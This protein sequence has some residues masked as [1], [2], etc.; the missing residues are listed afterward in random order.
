MDD[1]LAIRAPMVTFHVLRDSSGLYLI[2]TGFFWA[3]TLLHRA[4]RRRGWQDERIRGILLTHGHVDHVYNA[5]VLAKETGAWIAAPRLDALHLEGRFPYRGS[6][7]V[8]GALESI[9]RRVCGYPPIPITHC[10]TIDPTWESGMISAR[11]IC[12]DTPMATWDFFHQ[13]ASSCSA[14]I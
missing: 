12:P 6:A 5:A 1:L 3:R 11:C 7:R 9:C 10:W 13:A 14:A 4:L 8:C 2:D